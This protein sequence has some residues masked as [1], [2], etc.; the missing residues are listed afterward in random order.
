MEV[1]VRDPAELNVVV[2]VNVFAGVNTGVEKEEPISGSMEEV[3]TTCAD[4][5]PPP[6]PLPMSSVSV[7]ESVRRSIV[8]ERDIVERGDTGGR[9]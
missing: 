2:G 7:S 3:G 5:P 9:C 4:T 8:V 1:G 6:P